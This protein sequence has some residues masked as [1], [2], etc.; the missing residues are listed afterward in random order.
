MPQKMLS[1]KAL[2]DKLVVET[3][4]YFYSGSTTER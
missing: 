3:A 4:D 1:G 2:E